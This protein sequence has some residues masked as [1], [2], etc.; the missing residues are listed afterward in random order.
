MEPITRDNW[1]EV[2]RFLIEW[3]EWKGCENDPVLAHEKEAVFFAIDHFNELSIRGLIIRVFSKIGAMSCSNPS[4][5]IPRWFILKRDYRNAK[6][7][8]K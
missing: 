8:I 6:G 3:C 4:M 5:P 1:E 2:K 7:S